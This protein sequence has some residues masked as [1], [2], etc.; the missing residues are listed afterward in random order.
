MTETSIRRIS[1]PVVFLLA[2]FFG[3][4]PRALAAVKL[5]MKDG[6]FQLVKSYE[7]RGDRVRYY[8]IERSEWEEVPKSLVDFDAT[9]SA[10]REE[11][12]AVKKVLEEARAIDQK[13]FDEPAAAGLE[14]APGVHLPQ[15]EGVYIYD[16]LRVIRL[17]QSAAEVV[18]DKKRAALLLALPGPIL[19]SRALVVLPGPKAAIRLSKLQPIFYIQS[20]DRWGARAE[21]VPVK[22]GKQSRVVEKFQS[23]IGVGK[24]GELRTELPVERT[25][26]SPGL[27]K[28]TPVQPLAVGEYALGELL[29]EK[30]NLD[31]WDFGVDGAPKPEKSLAPDHPAPM[32]ER[33]P[34][35][36]P[37]R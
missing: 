1:L 32:S 21:L 16:G 23:G 10:Q 27:F 25:E 30:L 34:D 18:T 20:A 15:D 4:P 13:R 3:A 22:A 35:Q 8:S 31:L 29:Q 5:Y 12:S 17:V 7:V 14:I 24:K 37:Q 26:I 11:K 6:T 28:L 19:K 36:N 9:E 2:C 33:P